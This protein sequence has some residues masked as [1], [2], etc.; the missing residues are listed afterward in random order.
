MVITIKQSGN[1]HHNKIHNYIHST[2]QH[3]YMVSATNRNPF[4]IIWDCTHYTLSP[5]T[6]ISS[7]VTKMYALQQNA[8]FSSYST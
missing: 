4:K 2:V 3:M 6:L 8:H 7:A 1:G 5:G